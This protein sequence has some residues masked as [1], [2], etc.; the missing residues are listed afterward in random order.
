MIKPYLQDMNTLFRREIRFVKFKI[1]KKWK[2]RPTH[3]M[4]LSVGKV[5]MGCYGIGGDISYQGGG[6]PTEAQ[7]C[8]SVLDEKTVH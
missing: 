5:M 2:V 4:N 6:V 7:D 1:K 8:I 3:A